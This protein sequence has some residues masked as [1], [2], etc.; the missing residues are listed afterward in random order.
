MT[1]YPSMGSSTQ[2]TSPSSS[3]ASSLWQL[4]SV[5]YVTLIE[6]TTRVSITTR[7]DGTRVAPRAALSNPEQRI[8]YPGPGA[9]GGLALTCYGVC[10]SAH[11]RVAGVHCSGFL[12]PKRGFTSSRTSRTT[13][14]WI[15][16]KSRHSS[17]C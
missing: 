2:V 4:L 10:V 6:A 13:V 17:T 7:E 3:S 15:R 1:A 11:Y 8:R 9:A 14:C 5:E 16:R 12:G